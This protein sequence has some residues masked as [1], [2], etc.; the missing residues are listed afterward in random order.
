MQE[1]NQK[2]NMRIDIKKAYKDLKRINKHEEYLWDRIWELRCEITNYTLIHGPKS[3]IKTREDRLKHW[4]NLVHKA[5]LIQKYS[6]KLRK[7]DTIRWNETI[8]EPV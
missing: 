8:P 1:E 7:Y 4:D 6:Q 2:R 3:I 5:Q